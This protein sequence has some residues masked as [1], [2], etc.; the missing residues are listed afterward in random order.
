[1]VVASGT[2]SPSVTAVDLRWKNGTVVHVPI[3][4]VTGTRFASFAWD[5]ANPPEA[6]EQIGPAGVQ[7]IRIT[8]DKS[9]TWTNAKEPKDSLV[10]AAPP[11]I[12]TPT[13]TPNLSQTPQVNPIS[14]GILGA[15]TVSGHQWQLAYEIIPSGSAANSSNEV[16]CTDTTID[17]TTTQGGCTSSQPFATPGINFTYSTSHTQSPSPPPTAPPKQAPPQ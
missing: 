16:F 3:V 8:H 9:A 14:S 2:P 12:T 10:Q 13:G 7:S 15:G 6:V 5:P 17:T 1:M 4:T 11:P